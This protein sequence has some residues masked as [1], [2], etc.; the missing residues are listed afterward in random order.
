M[1][2]F[3]VLAGG[4]AE[5]VGALDGEIHE[6]NPIAYDYESDSDLEDDGGE[7]EG[8][9]SNTQAQSWPKKIVE[10]T[11]STTGATT[12]PTIQAMGTAGGDIRTVMIK[13]SAY[14]TWQNLLFYLYTGQVHYAPLKSQGVE[15]RQSE[16][17][18]YRA[19][20]PR[21]PPPCSPKSMYRLADILGLDGLKLSAAYAIKEKLSAKNILDELCSTFSSRYSDI[22]DEQVKYFELHCRNTEMVP[23]LRSK[24]ELLSSGNIN[25]SVPALVDLFCLCL[26]ELKAPSS[27]TPPS[28]AEHATSAKR[29][30]F[31]RPWWNIVRDYDTAICLSYS[32]PVDRVI[33]SVNYYIYTYH[34]ERYQSTNLPSYSETETHSSKVAFPDMPSY[35][36]TGASRGIGLAFVAEL[37]QNA[38]NIV[39]ATARNPDA[40]PGLRQLQEQYP[41][42]RLAIV[43]MDVADTSSVLQAAETAAALLPNGLDWLISNA[44]IALQPG[45]TYEDCNLDALE[46]ELQVNT[47]GPIKVVRA[48]LPLIRQGDLRKIALISSGLASLEMAPAYC[49]ISNT[50]ALTKAALNMCAFSVK[51]TVVQADAFMS[52]LGRRWGTMLQSEGITMILIDPGWVATDMGHTIDDWMRQKAPDIPSY[53]PRQS[54]ARCLRIISDAKLE[55]AVEFYSV[56]GVKD[57]W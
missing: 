23:Q 17:R 52:R 7:D 51:P 14:T 15:L 24:L 21:R 53:T 42:D 9:A 40:S 29:T 16:T 25:H 39:V 3:L 12:T 56:E 4:F 5:S 18:K 8:E 48:F 20:H 44:G 36:I 32:F 2:I 10:S 26:I 13:D 28:F 38:S 22:K 37:L 43:P 27:P 33:F 19:T 30:G 34:L 55:N 45:V 31:R 46:Q 54:A 6:T 1:G 49:E 50:Y 41:K 35:L 47:I 11:G 57:P